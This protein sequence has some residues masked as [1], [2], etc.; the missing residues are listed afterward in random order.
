MKN[1]QISIDI[2]SNKCYN[3]YNYKKECTKHE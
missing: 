2:L 3:I 1:M